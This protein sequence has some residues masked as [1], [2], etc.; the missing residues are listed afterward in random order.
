[1]GN[2]PFAWC[3]P[4]GTLPGVDLMH[5]ADVPISGLGGFM[6]SA[7]YVTIASAAL[8][9]FGPLMLI[10]AAGIKLASPGPVF[11]MQKRIGYRNKAFMIFKFRTMP[12][13]D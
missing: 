4:A 13:A 8:L 1:M 3:A 12:A 9:L 5:L 10:C 7:M 11:F 6:K 2:P